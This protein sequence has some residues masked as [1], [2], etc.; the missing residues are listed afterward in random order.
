MVKV[1]KSKWAIVAVGKAGGKIRLCVD[2]KDTMNPNLIVDDHPLPTV[3]ELFN[4]LAEGKRFSK[5]DLNQAYLQL[6]LRPQD[7]EIL[8]LNTHKGLYKPTSLMFGVS[9]AP[10]IFQ[11]IMEQILHGI[12]E[13]EVFIDD[14]LVTGKT[15]AKH[16]CNLEE[17][18]KRLSCTT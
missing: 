11:R 13:V 3:Y 15:T 17:V 4:S 10:A 7:H 18:L 9:P 2:Y 14:I 5:I 8:V 12:P 6:N 16:L 1:D